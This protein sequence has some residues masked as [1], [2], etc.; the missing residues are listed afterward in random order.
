MTLSKFAV[1]SRVTELNRKIWLSEDTHYRLDI[2]V[3]TVKRNIVDLAE[4]YQVLTPETAL[5]G[6]V[7]QNNKVI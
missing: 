5:V 6:V 7:K 2:N 1:K 3:N 4:K